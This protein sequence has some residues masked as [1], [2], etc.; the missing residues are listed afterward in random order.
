[1]TFEGQSLAEGLAAGPVAAIAPLSFWGGYDSTTGLIIDR[2]HPACGR[3]LAGTVL[4]MASGRGSSSEPDRP[5]RQRWCAP[6]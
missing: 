5:R 4:V 2:H 1:M 6:R 3:S